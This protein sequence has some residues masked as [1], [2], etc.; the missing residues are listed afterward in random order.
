MKKL[1]VLNGVVKEFGLTAEDVVKNW[2][3]NGDVHADFLQG[4]YGVAE[5][6]Q[7][8]SEISFI[9]SK[10]FVMPKTIAPG[11]FYYA[12]GLIFPELIKDNQVSAVIGC[13]NNNHGLAIGL[14]ETEL[15]WSSDYLFVDMASDLSGKEA[16]ETIIKAAKVQGKNAEAAEW[17]T[18]Y[19]FD[20]IE[21]GTMFMP[22][23]EELRSIFVNSKKLRKSFSVLKQQGL[24]EDRFY[25]SSSENLSYAWHI[26]AFNGVGNYGSK[27][28]SKPVRCALEFTI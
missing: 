27:G 24:Q 7:P 5:V 21:V 1:E 8:F 16:T 17:C 15:P 13:M 28:G 6:K 3:A 12:D 23:D 11:M 18:K 19:A 9:P 14:R 26:N 22:S 4:L 20:G 2:Y 25:W 10:K